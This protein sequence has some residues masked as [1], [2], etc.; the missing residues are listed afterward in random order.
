[1]DCFQTILGEESQSVRKNVP[2][3]LSFLSFYLVLLKT[4]KLNPV[5]Y[6]RFREIKREIFSPGKTFNLHSID[7]IF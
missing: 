2:Y 6:P 5:K 1:M 4:K 3:T 7:L